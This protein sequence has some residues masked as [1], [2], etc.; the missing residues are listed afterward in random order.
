MCQAQISLS[1]DNKAY[2]Q[3]SGENSKWFWRKTD[4][5]NAV[6]RPKQYFFGKLA[7]Y[8]KKTS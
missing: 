2:D 5:N 1:H 7:S 8:T 3:V 4:L 6:H